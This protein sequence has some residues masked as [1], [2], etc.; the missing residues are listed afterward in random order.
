MIEEQGTVLAVDGDFAWVETRRQSSCGSCAAKAG[1]GTRVLGRLMGGRPGRLRALN[2]GHARP[3]D[4]VVIGIPEAGLLRGSLAVYL[5]PLLGLIGGG[6]LGELL[7]SRLFAP[8]AE[9]PAMLGGVFGF[10]AGLRWVQRFS[11]R[12]RDDA[13]FQPVVL[14][15]V[16]RQVAIPLQRLSRSS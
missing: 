4:P 6:L 5:L 3:G 13:R 9:W 8:A 11:R 15:R 14:R 12:I 10:L 7:A 1:C 2:R 16:S